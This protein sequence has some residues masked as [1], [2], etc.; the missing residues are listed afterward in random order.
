MSEPKPTLEYKSPDL[1]HSHKKLTGGDLSLIMGV[2]GFALLMLVFFIPSVI[3]VALPLSQIFGV[4][5][6]IRGVVS[7][8]RRQRGRAS[9][10]VGMTLGTICAAMLITGFLYVGYS[11]MR[12]VA[13]ARRMA[14]QG[15]I[16]NLCDAIER[17]R[18]DVGRY[19]A[20]AEG[21]QALV[22]QPPGVSGWKQYLQEVPTDKWGR[23]Y[24]Y[25][26]PSPKDP[27][28]FEITSAG[29]DGVFGTADDLNGVSR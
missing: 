29:E 14:T 11:G 16:F 3:C 19:P 24:R 20:S 4:I 25:E 9:A 28:T 6:I 17:F 7:L 5:A 10:I 21:L 13:D 15:E 18:S 23:P 26:F 8:V 27:R 12:R 1:G 2:T 22:I